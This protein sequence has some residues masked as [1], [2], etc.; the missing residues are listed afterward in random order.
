M[1]TNIA[2]ASG[3]VNYFEPDL[4]LTNHSVRRRRSFAPVIYSC[5]QPLLQTVPRLPMT[6]PSAELA[7]PVGDGRWSI[8]E[9]GVCL[10]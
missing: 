6:S 5:V 8:F 3:E 4:I 9:D 10:F 7:L 2:G 1:Q